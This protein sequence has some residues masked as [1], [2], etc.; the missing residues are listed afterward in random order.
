[1]DIASA[2]KRRY[3]AKI[4]DTTRPVP[5][6]VMGQILEALHLSPSSVNSQPWH[7]IVATTPEA[8]AR[9]AKGT[10]GEYAFNEPKV[11]TA[12][13]VVLFCV[14]T[15]VDAGYEDL[16]LSQEQRDG[17]YS[18][19]EAKRNWAA[20]RSYFIDLH[21]YQGR[22]V[23]HWMEKQVYLSLGVAMTTAA[24]LGVDTTP[25]EGIDTKI[26]DQEFGLRE[27]GLTASVMLSFGYHAEGDFNAKLPKS[28]LKKEQVFTTL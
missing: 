1:M 28:R 4:Y 13:H 5:D 15:G 24:V 25:L 17:R 22:D 11:T 18:D 9:M 12:S 19:E 26:L 21:R 6:E 7:F 14:R 2:A 3:T 27:K 8:K 23:V 10:Q 20:G 16:L